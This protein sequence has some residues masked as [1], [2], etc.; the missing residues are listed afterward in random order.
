MDTVVFEGYTGISLGDEP[1]IYDLFLLVIIVLLSCFALVFRACYPLF[2][3]MIRGVVTI[4][5]RRNLFDNPTQETF[6]FDMFMRF[7]TLLLCAF[8]FF[9]VF[10]RIAALPRQNVRQTLILLAVFFI[11]LFMF[12]LLKRFLYYIYGRTFTETVKFSL[13]NTTWHTLFYLWGILLYFPVLWLM[14][15]RERFVGALI[16]FVFTYILFR[17]LV[18]YVLIRIFYHKNAGLLYLSLYLCAQ[19]IVPLLFLYKSLTYLHNV[20]EASILWQ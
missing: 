9:Q 1:L 19:E 7:Q 10:C 15:D 12:Y 17:I 20:I 13:W 4:K 14:F 16:V 3:Q 5:E 6:F 18:I 11:I 2:V 8:V